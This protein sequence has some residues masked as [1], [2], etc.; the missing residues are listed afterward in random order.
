MSDAERTEFLEWYEVQKVAVFDNKGVS[1]SY[2]QDEV[3]VL[4]QASEVLRCG[5]ME[6]G[7]IDMFLESI[8]IA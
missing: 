4:R 7:N 3:T 6:I 2:W 5:F 1:E 8:T